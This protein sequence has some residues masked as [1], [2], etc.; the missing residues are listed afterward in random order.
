MENFADLA[1]PLTKLTRNKAKFQWGLEQEAGFQ[2]LKECLVQPPILA[3]PLEQ[4]GSMIL[5]CDES[6]TAVGGVHFL[7]QS[8]TKSSPEKLL[9][10]QKRVVQYCLLCSTF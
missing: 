9:Y 8:Y 7:W 2:K 10:N 6:G 5:D 3:F 1:L 4:G